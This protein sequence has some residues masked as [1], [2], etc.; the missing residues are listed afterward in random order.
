MTIVVDSP[1]GG[2]CPTCQIEAPVPDLMFRPRQ[3]HP[4]QG[5]QSY[6]LYYSTRECEGGVILKSYQ[7]FYGVR[8]PFL[9]CLAWSQTLRTLIHDLPL[10]TWRGGELLPLSLLILVCY[11]SELADGQMSGHRDVACPLSSSRLSLSRTLC[12]DV[13]LLS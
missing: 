6:I 2:W 3:P 10:T 7:T 13:L 8:S 1:R 9:L 5:S 11:W 4:D 12:C